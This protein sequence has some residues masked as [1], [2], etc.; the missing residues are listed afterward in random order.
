MGLARS[1]GQY[2]A[3]VD[4][5]DPQ[6]PLVQD[7]VLLL[8]R[9]PHHPQ[10]FLLN[11]FPCNLWLG[12]TTTTTWITH[13]RNGGIIQCNLRLVWAT[14]LTPLDPP[15][16]ALLIPTF[17]YPLELNLRLSPLALPL[18]P[19]LFHTLRTPRN[20]PRR[21]PISLRLALACPLLP[22]RHPPPQSRAVA[23]SIPMPPHSFPRP[24]DRTRLPLRARTGRRL[25]WSR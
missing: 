15:L 7:S 11:S 22:Q 19:M 18:W 16:R 3:L 20:L 14:H 1:H 13:R 25:N 21:T 24:L 9:I 23:A 6:S 10:V 17:P 8:I 12:L 5:V 2:L 4:P